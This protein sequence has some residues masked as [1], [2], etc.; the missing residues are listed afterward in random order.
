MRRSSNG[1]GCG[2]W[3]GDRQAV[4]RAAVPAPVVMMVAMLLLLLL[5][6]LLLLLGRLVVPL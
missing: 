4:S 3:P 1:G 5:M 6:L 2:D